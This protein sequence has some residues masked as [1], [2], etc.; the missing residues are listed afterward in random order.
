[1]KGE[2]WRLPEFIDAHKGTLLS[3]YSK[4]TP[5]QKTGYQDHVLQLRAKKQQ[6]IRDNPKRIQRDM[7]A[8]F[9]AMD[10]EVCF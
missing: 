8:S 10:Q 5:A 9:D 4:L 6:I 2:C 3:H 7:Q 1:L